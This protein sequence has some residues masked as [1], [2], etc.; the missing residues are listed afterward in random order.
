MDGR[1]GRVEITEEQ[2]IQLNPEICKTACNRVDIKDED[3]PG[4]IKDCMK[5]NG[6]RTRKSR[7]NSRK[8]K[9][10]KRKSRKMAKSN[11]KRRRH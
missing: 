8:Y 5:K 1:R 6:G 2:L 9:R 3:R 11:K 10:S 4:C 7:R